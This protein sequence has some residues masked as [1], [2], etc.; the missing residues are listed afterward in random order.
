MTGEWRYVPTRD[1][2]GKDVVQ[3]RR[4][5]RVMGAYGQLGPLL[6]YLERPL[7]CWCLMHLKALQGRNTLE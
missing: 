6:L 5:L 3:E 4:A 7:I 2:R 1:V